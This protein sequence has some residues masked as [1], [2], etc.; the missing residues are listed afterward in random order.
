L[1]ENPTPGGLS[2]NKIFALLFQEYGF[3]DEASVSDPGKMIC[4]P[5]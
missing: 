1:I 3:F 4:G 5:I 2:K